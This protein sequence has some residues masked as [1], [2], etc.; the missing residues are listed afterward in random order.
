MKSQS[1][2]E[3]ASLHFGI[4]G[5]LAFVVFI[6]I[7]REDWADRYRYLTYLLP[8]PV[9]SMFIAKKLPLLGGLMMIA[10]GS[11]AAIFDVVF[12]PAHPGRITG[13]GLGYTFVFVT[14]PLA[15]SGTFY[16]IHWWK[17]R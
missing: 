14:L 6:L 7:F 10:L 4:I 3:D 11:G 12:S 13:R 9:I 5:A 2:F 15:I 1:A 8:L 16:M 17:F